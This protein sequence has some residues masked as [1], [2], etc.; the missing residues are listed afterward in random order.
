MTQAGL[1]AGETESATGLREP[2]T[3]PTEGQTTA[4]TVEALARRGA[5]WV[6]AGH[7]LSSG[8]R[9]GANLLLARLL[10]PEAFGLMALVRVLLQGLQLFSDIGVGPS[11][12][13]NKRGEDPAFLN[14]AWTV[15]VVR[16]IV[17]GSCCCVLAWPYAAFYGEAT[18]SWLVPV[19]GLSAVLAGFNSTALFVLNRRLALGKLAILDLATQ[20]VSVIVMLAW[21]LASPTVWALAAGG[22]AGASFR[23]VYSHLLLPGPRNRLAWDRDAFQELYRF[24]RWIFLATAVGFLATQG[25]RLILGKLLPLE[26]LGVYSIA[27]MIADLP[28]ELVKRLGGR[29]V[30]PAVSQWQGW[31]R[32]SLRAKILAKRWPVLCGTAFLLTGLIGFGDLIIRILYD[33]RYSAAA[34]MMPL[35]ALGLWPLVLSNSIGPSLRA[36]GQPQYAAYGNL[37]RL[38]LIGVSLP[39]GYYLFGPAGAVCAVALAGIPGYAAMAVGLRRH[40]LQSVGQ[41]VSATA[42]LVVLLLGVFAARSLAGVAMPFPGVSSLGGMLF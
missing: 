7:G 18:L 15:Q 6:V 19:V 17:L 23:L 35:L 39:L 22:I 33:D 21:A 38:I 26:V 4:P 10:V 41:D 27:F 11:I 13:Q 16:G 30:F 32:E 36:I 31:P 20:A 42:L 2:W 12:I 28:R 37:L 24:G 14:T 1:S 34:W 3:E 5:A 25:D 9:L 29:I 8:L 40:G